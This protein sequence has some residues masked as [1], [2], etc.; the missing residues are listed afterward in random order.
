MANG[1]DV[2]I[3]VDSTRPNRNW[4]ASW[5]TGEAAFSA[6]RVSCSRLTNG[7][8]LTCYHQPLLDSCAS[9]GKY[10]ECEPFNMK[11][12]ETYSRQVDGCKLAAGSYD[13]TLVVWNENGNKC[14]E[15]K[16]HSDWITSIC[17]KKEA[18]EQHLFVTGSNDKV[19]DRNIP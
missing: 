19:I 17:W 18:G 10:V 13:G 11:V 15:V 3:A 4:L 2:S 12:T 8:K 9:T 16:K 5:T 6:E 1:A 14:F 7:P